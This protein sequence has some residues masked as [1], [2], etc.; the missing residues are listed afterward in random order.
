MNIRSITLGFPVTDL[1]LAKSWYRRLFPGSEELD[2]VDGVWEMAPL[3]EVWLQL[4]E[5]EEQE[6]SSNVI[7]FETDDLTEAFHLVKQLGAVIITAP[8][9]VPGVVEY[10][11]FADPFGNLLSFYKLPD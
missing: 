11:E 6:S 9:T 2:P 8:E 3:S 4:F 10:F 5:Q 7:R 1:D